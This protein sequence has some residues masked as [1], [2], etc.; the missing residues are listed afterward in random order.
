MWMPPVPTSLPNASLASVPRSIN[1]QATR[2]VAA[3]LLQPSLHIAVENMTSTWTLPQTTMPSN[4]AYGPM[5]VGTDD[6]AINADK[7]MGVELKQP[8]QKTTPTAPRK[9]AS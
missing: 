9:R 3:N 6:T 8:P 5:P 7:Q 4:V 2:N 1:T